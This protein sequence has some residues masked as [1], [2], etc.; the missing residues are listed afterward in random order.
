MPYAFLCDFDGTVSP[1]DIGAAL[2]RRF[3]RDGAAEQEARLA[4]W[5]AGAIG[6]RALTEEQCR[7]VA[8]GGEEAL[9][10]CRG[11]RLD[12]HFAPFVRESL[13]R[14]DAVMVVSEGFDFYV[15]DHLARVGLPDLPWAANHALFA[16]GRLVPEFPYAAGGCGDCGNCKAQHVRRYQ[17]LGFRAV[18]VGDGLSDRCGAR[19]A[20]A[21]LA[22]GELLDWCRRERLPARDFTGFADVADWARQLAATAPAARRG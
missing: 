5:L 6:H 1:V 10:F 18:L 12:P 15:C 22:R 8:A 2:I 19:V 13:G 17:A 14:G 7:G 4:R 9:E 3:S 16:D 21:V 20:D 11:F